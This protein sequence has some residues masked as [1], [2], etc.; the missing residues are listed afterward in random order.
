MDTS[1]HEKHAKIFSL[2]MYISY[3]ILIR[4]LESNYQENSPWQI[5]KGTLKGL[6]TDS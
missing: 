1:F 3:K 2:F 5:H 4:C 6:G